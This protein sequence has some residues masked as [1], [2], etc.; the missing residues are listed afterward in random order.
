MLANRRERHGRPTAV[1]LAGNSV[2]WRSIL[3][4]KRSASKRA[5]GKTS[6]R[7]YAGR[8][9]WGKPV[10]K[11]GRHKSQAQILAE[12][13]IMSSRPDELRHSRRSSSIVSAASRCNDP[14]RV[15]FAFTIQRTAKIFIHV[16]REKER[17][18]ERESQPKPRCAR[19][20]S[21]LFVSV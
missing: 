18:R 21:L 10:G 20:R 15:H 1:K 13:P 4:E 8:R 19:A 3:T 5:K 11:R 16:K 9:V 6:V 12:K 7:R 2:V 14:T 17:E